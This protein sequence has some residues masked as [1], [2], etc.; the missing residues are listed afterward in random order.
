MFPWLLLLLCAAFAADAGAQRRTTR[1]PAPQKPAPMKTEPAIVKCPDS[2]GTGLRT[3]HEYCFVPAG[4]DAAQGVLVSIPPHVGDATLIFDLHNR[5]TYSEERVKEGRG[6]A[7]YMA[8]IG[9][10]TM[11]ME[12][13]RRAAVMSEFRT[14]ADLYERIGGGA[15]PSGAKAVAPIGQERVYVTIPPG[16]DQVSLLGELLEAHTAAGVER[17]MPGRP[18]ALVS[19]IQVEYRPAP[20]PRKR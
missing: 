12:I 10:L 4:S 5:H 16:I 2:L 6:F 13:L 14:A 9:V 19:N 15:G 17:T 20:A 18:V 11:K 1:K 7:K 3:G 8:G